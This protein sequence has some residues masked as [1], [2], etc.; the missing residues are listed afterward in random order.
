M[1]GALVVKQRYFLTF[2]GSSAAALCLTMPVA[3]QNAPSSQPT[4][5][6]PLTLVLAIQEAEARYPAIRA[7]QDR[8]EAARSAI[9]VAKTAY[10][11]RADMLWET[12]RSTTNRPNIAVIP[13]PIVPIPSPPA[14]AVTGHSDWNTATGVL[15]AWQ[16]FDFGQRHAQVGVARFGYESA[17]RA[18]ELSRLDV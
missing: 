6:G 13:Q 16:P 11:P 3:G 9:D 5:N 17:Q 1:E 2:L 10:L 14:R 18:T 15:L 4:I 12:S 7:A 8:Q